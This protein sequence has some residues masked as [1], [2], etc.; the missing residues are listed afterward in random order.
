MAADVAAGMR[1]TLVTVFRGATHGE[2]RSE[3]DRAAAETLGCELI[4]LG[5][6]EAGAR[7]EISGKMGVFAPLGQ[8]H[9]AGIAQVVARLSAVV[10][11]GASVVAPLGVGGH[12]DHRM[13]QAAAR[14]LV[15]VR[16]LDLSF[17]ED[18][19]YSLEPYAL[20]RRMAGLAARIVTP[21][22]PGSSDLKLASATFLPRASAAQEV[23]SYARYLARLPMGRT[24][25]PWG[26]GWF[27]RLIAARAAVGADRPGHQ[28]GPAVVLRPVPR[29]V[30]LFAERRFVACAA[31]ASQWRLFFPSLAALREAYF[32]HGKSIVPEAGPDTLWERCWALCQKDIVQ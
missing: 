32:S 22:S 9:L 21:A 5:L 13:V 23:F 2:R 17:Y 11:E 8:V 1:V 24:L 26:T 20:G 6:P 19:P 3:E 28:P 18:L 15:E 31:Y 7:P 4:E 29:D 27:M 16:P 10:P 25:G 12:I 30:T 14:A